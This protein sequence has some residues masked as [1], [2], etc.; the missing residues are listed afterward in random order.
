MNHIWSYDFVFDRT[1]DGQPIKILTLI[2]EFTRE[3]L[4]I[5]VARSIK[6]DDLIELLAGVMLERGMPKHIR[7]DNGPE[8]A[9]EAV[10]SWLKSMRTETLFVEPGAPWENGYIESFNSR[11]RDELL[12]GEVFT[13]LSEAKYLAEDWRMMY[14]T[15]RLH[16][17]LNY[18]TPQEFAASCAPYDSAS[19]Q[20][21]HIPRGFASGGRPAAIADWQEDVVACLEHRQVRTSRTSLCR[22]RP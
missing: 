3:S 20:L 13:G 10:R 11:L 17:S 8:F 14:N 6:G 7:S 15:E 18:L 4:S 9:A 22:L 16:S 21:T 1:Q 5:H 19:T 2:D 12:N